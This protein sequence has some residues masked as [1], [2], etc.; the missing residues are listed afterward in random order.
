MSS[1]LLIAVI[2]TK[3]PSISS[4]TPSSAHPW[5]Y[6]RMFL[7]D[8]RNNIGPHQQLFSSVYCKAKSRFDA[9]DANTAP[10]IF[11]IGRKTNKT[12]TL[13]FCKNEPAAKVAHLKGIQEPLMTRVSRCGARKCRFTRN[14]PA[15]CIPNLDSIRFA[16]VL[17][18][19]VVCKGS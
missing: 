15:L 19:K 11:L 18:V 14:R 7:L 16:W 1:H 10:S 6:I 5:L 4:R 17:K 2:F 12:I 9:A 3:P 13:Y 8:S